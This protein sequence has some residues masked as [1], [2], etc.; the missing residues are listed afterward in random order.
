MRLSR[1][2]VGMSDLKRSQ[3]SVLG[4]YLW[5]VCKARLS[6]MFAPPNASSSPSI[7]AQVEQRDGASGI[8]YH[9]GFTVPLSNNFDTEQVNTAFDP[10]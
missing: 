1:L 4:L 6:S 9:T 7:A 5:M 2:A 3:D 10:R 8:L